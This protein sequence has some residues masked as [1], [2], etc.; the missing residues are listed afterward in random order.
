MPSRASASVRSS[1]AA[2]ENARAAEIDVIVSAVGLE[3]ERQGDRGN[4]AAMVAALM[5][6][7]AEQVESVGV[8]WFMRQHLLVMLGRF[9]ESP[10]SVQGGAARHQLDQIRA[11][12]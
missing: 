11:L 4:G 5:P 7:D 9:G 8:V 1:A 6:G 3:R 12:G 10:G 2:R